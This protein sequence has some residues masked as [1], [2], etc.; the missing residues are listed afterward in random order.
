MVI[1]S[2]I[3]RGAAMGITEIMPGISGS[4][5]AMLMGIYERL[6]QS[7]SDLTKGNWQRAFGFLVPLG[8]GMV[9]A[10]LLFSHLIKYL[11]KHHE[12]PLFYLFVGLIIGIL[13]FLWRS[14]RTHSKKSFRLTHLIL[15]VVSFA[16]VAL[17]RFVSEPTTTVIT[18]LDTGTYLFLFASGWIAST[19]LVLP[20]VS[21]SLM[22]MVLGVYHTAISS[23]TTFNVPVI[24]A[25]GLGVCAGILITSRVIRFFFDTYTQATY[26]V[27]FG[28]VAGSII[29]IFPIGMPH[30]FLYGLICALALFAG[31]MTAITFGKAERAM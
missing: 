1:W 27:M 2:N 29:V 11:L 15:M 10:L 5:I 16:L 12:A 8:I 28:L 22:L 4:T 25:I 7:L 17:M 9:C 26:A 13:P 3:I 14:G 19:A 18:N 31:F 23:L 6:L 21:G 30:S 24:T 20:G